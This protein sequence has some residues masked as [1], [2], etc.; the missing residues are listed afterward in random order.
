ML[1]RRSDSMYEKIKYSDSLSLPH[2]IYIDVRSP[3][4]YNDGHIPGAINLPI[5][6]DQERAHVGTIYKQQS[7]EEAKVVGM[8]YASARLPQIFE[9]I[10]PYI[11]SDQVIIYCRG[12]GFRSRSIVGLL[13][14]LGE[15]VMQLD[16]GYKSYRR[17]I[18]QQIEQKIA[19]LQ[20][21][22]LN[23]YTGVGKTNILA[24]LAKR[25][26]QVINLEA[27]ANH[28]GSSFGGIGLGTQPT[29]KMFESA[30]YEVIHSLESGY[31]FIESESSKIG[32]VFVPN[33]L[34]DAYTHTH[35]QVL[36]TSPDSLRV[37]RI[38]QEYIH[39]DQATFK[40]EVIRSLKTLHRYISEDNYDLIQRMLEHHHFEATISLLMKHYYDRRY[41]MNPY[42]Y[43]LVIDHTYTD[44][45]VTQLLAHYNL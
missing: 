12:G 22:T 8:A 21:I 26:Y 13:T 23:G 30:L 20:F 24:E 2:P 38:Y 27:V 6:N 28:R 25:G 45:A 14:S 5:M 4:E 11:H 37:Q 36:I 18:T 39:L 15:P 3:S 35:H 17:Y 16:G 34:R 44:Q 29:Q 1:L 31:V 10:L 19:T 7:P 9:T 32:N 41:Q 43:E 42:E 40:E 33:V